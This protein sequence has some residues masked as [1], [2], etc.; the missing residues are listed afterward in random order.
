VLATRGRIAVRWSRPL[1]GTPTTVTGSRAADG[2]LACCPC[3][4]VLVPPLSPTGHETGID[5]GLES[6][7]TVGERTQI[8]T[9][10]TP[11]Q[12]LLRQYDPISYDPISYEDVPTASTSP[13]CSGCGRIVSTG[14]PVR[15]HACPARGTSLQRD[16]H[17]AQHRASAGHSRRGAVV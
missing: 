7:A 4:D 16:H 15:W 11:V 17:A 8:K 14:V 2:W 9:P 6:L 3:A 13:A 12:V 10:V 1:A 5:R